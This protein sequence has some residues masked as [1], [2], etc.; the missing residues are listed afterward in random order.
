M[1]MSRMRHSEC[2]RA[3]SKQNNFKVTSLN[4][5]ERPCPAANVAAYRAGRPQRERTNQD[6]PRGSGHGW[7]KA[8]PP[9]APPGRRRA[10]GSEMSLSATHNRAKTPLQARN[11]HIASPTLHTVP[12]DGPLLPYTPESRSSKSPRDW[13]S[14]SIR[15]S[16]ERRRGASSQV[17][18]EQTTARRRV[19]SA[20]SI[21]RPAGRTAGIHPRSAQLRNAPSPPGQ[22]PPAVR[23]MTGPDRR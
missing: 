21:P 6:E 22:R 12:R 8:S 18:D 14:L 16:M 3:K 9:P 20:L 4:A 11:K 2:H 17:T 10:P 1:R 5:G 19:K 7:I 15:D 23:P 13:G